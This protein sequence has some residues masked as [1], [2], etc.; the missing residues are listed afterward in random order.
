MAINLKQKHRI[1]TSVN[2]DRPKDDTL[3]IEDFINYHT[4]FVREKQLEN[5]SLRTIEDHKILF[6]YLTRWIEQSH[7]S[8]TNQCVQKS[9][10]LDYKEY[11]LFE[12]NYAPCTVNLRLRPIKT[13]INWLL[14]QEHIKVN[15]N[16][17]I[18]LVKVS[19]DR[20]HPLSRAEVKRL[21]NAIGD[22][23]YA[24]Y[25]DLII[26]LT[27]LDCGIRI[28]E[29]LQLTVHD[30]NFKESFILVRASVSKTRTERVLPISRQTLAYLE[31]LRDIALEQNQEHLFLASSG[32]NV[33]NRNDVFH[34][35]RRYK[36]E[37][38][39][40]K[41]C[42]PY[43]L[44][45]TFATEMVKIGV[46]IFTLQRMMGHKNITTTRQYVF[47]DNE[48]LIS[49]HKSSGILNHFLG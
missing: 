48:D 4:D 11:M 5:L 7:W 23:T 21:I 38:N 25:R 41:K 31:Q 47:L 35:F 17:F 20:V 34:N 33:L 2:V 24:R 22:S 39:I 30:V 44:R 32:E 15:Y 46:D 3:T 10:F 26:T 13:Y 37:A 8:D 19:D 29:L 28:F 49:K 43:V 36:A 12:K 14:K 18:K 16:N 27:I 9:I 6:R 45:H 1:Q 42:T 40:T